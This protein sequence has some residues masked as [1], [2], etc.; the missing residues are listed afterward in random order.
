MSTVTPTPDERPTASVRAYRLADAIADMAGRYGDSERRIAF[1]SA[2]N[3]DEVTRH[4]RAASRRYRA[5]LRL[6]RALRDL[7]T[8]PCTAPA[9]Y[10]REDYP[11]D[12]PLQPGVEGRHLGRRARTR[13]AGHE[14]TR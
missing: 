3:R 6:V 13:N 10:E 9:R 5:M 12:E 7:D 1:S 8:R 4:V 2:F 11:T 14:G